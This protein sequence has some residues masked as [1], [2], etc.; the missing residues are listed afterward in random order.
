MCG[1][2]GILNFDID[3]TIDKS[4]LKKM[5]EVLFH[6]GPDDEGMFIYG[7]CGLG[8]RRLSI[9]D[10]DGGHQPMCNE[11]G[12]IWIVF[13]GEIYNHADLKM[14]LLSRGHQY[15]TRCDTETIIHLYE[16]HGIDGFKKMNGMFAFAIWDVQ[17]KKLVMA[18]DRLGIK[19]L[20]YTIFNDSLIFASEIKSILLFPGV[21]AELNDESLEEFLAFRYVSGEKSLFKNILDLL[22]GHVF[23][24]D[25][26]EKYT[27]K[28]W[29]IHLPEHHLDID[30]KTAINQLEERLRN[31]VKLQL[32]SD[33]PLGTFLSGGVD[34][35][36]ISA[37]A[38]QLSNSELH[39][40]SVG[41]YEKEWDETKYAKRISQKYNTNHHPI[42]ID[43][44]LYADSLPRLIWYHDSPLYHPSTVLIYHVS[45][46]ARQYVKVVLTGEG[47]DELFGG[48]PRYLIPKVCSHLHSL[49][50][51]SRYLLKE[52]ITKFPNRK[53]NK[54]GYFMPLPLL[55]VVL[56][57]SLYNTPK[58]I[59]SLLSEDVPYSFLEYRISIVADPKLTKKN[60]I[61]YTMYSDL[62]N[63][64]PSLLHRQD[65]MS[66][67]TSLESRVP[68]LDH[69]LVEWGVNVPLKYKIRAMENK[70]I[71]K[72]LGEKM[73]PRE[74]IYRQKVGFSVPVSDWLKD[75]S[76]LGRYLELFS[77]KSF[78]LRSYFESVRIQ[79]LIDEHLTG[80][81][82]HCEIL[83]NLINFELWYRIFI[84]KSI[85]PSEK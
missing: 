80:K 38:S 7:N 37:F 36:L 20:H 69:T 6:R 25:Y 2:C 13:N 1:I 85:T 79:Q 63:Y 83:W 40:F 50:K 45:K 74:A 27:K 72:R 62:K 53:L 22:P 44:S 42:R 19:P 8:F 31:S 10:L 21:K 58:L 41:F 68:F 28:F 64:I 12:N 49:P 39:T 43:R 3:K 56:Y 4:V 24:W 57:N 5:T 34:S 73:L 59:R 67:A 60:L 70:Y 23:V 84:E 77:D 82:N 16:E 61:E 18:R 11:R 71:V 35:S 47:A 55:E 52:L 46:M 78:K 26:G 33:V 76:G 15:K 29:D 75:K 65:K 30:E 17:K 81:Y 48:Y 14:E 32:M 54:L 66:M 51:F 9:I